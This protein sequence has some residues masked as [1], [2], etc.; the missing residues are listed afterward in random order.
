MD[1]ELRQQL[2]EMEARL[3][4]QVNRSTERILDRL[5]ALEGDVRNLRSEHSV[6]RDTVLKLPGTVL[7]AIEEPLL[8]RITA[9]ETRVT[10]LEP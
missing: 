1:E 3:V 2:L 4:G 9:I 10:K 8:R 6:T 7:G 5:T